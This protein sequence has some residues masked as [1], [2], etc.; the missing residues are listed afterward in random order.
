MS[1]P[2]HA[3]ASR[4]S[5]RRHALYALLSCAIGIIGALILLEIA[6]RFLPV[7]EPLETQPID[8]ANP[9]MHFKPNNDVVFS[10]GWNF[11]I[12]NKVHVNN[13]GFINDQDYDANA[14][15]PLLT[16][17][18]DS[19]IE[20]EHVPYPHTLQ[21]RLA[22]R[23]GER[24]RV[25]SFGASGSALSQYLAY[26]QLARDAFHAD[27]LAVLIIANDFDESLLEYKSDPGFHYLKSDGNG[28][29][30]LQLVPFTPSLIHQAL[31]RSALARY[32]HGNGFVV[33]ARRHI[34]SFFGRQSPDFVGNTAAAAD[35]VRLQKSQ[36][37]ADQFL[38]M[39]P[40]YSG[41]TPDRIVLL[42]DGI[43]PDLYD[44]YKL[45]EAERSYFARMRTYFIA[46]AH[47]QGYK[48]ADL[49]PRFIARYQRDGVRFEWDIDSHWNSSAHEVAADAVLDSGIP[50][51]LFGLP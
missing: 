42:V 38:A 15:T 23:I 34:E 16:V 13:Y 24:G 35:S 28:S 43:R 5:R 12:V 26:A 25:Y 8:S 48:V 20:A 39:L 4:G 19:Y 46:Q 37:A 7:R 1:A 33:S 30:V 2:H 18:G 27:A 47:K 45:K 11:E 32:V 49:Q 44:A 51:R 29:H 3:P 50:Q 9:Y 6:L 41:L 31:R 36:Q 17:I 14:T 21:G 40:D 22:E 10:M